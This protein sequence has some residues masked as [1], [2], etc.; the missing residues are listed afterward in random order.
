M[1]PFLAPE[2]V[3]SRSAPRTLRRSAP[4]TRPTAGPRGL[5]AGRRGELHQLGVVPAHLVR[6]IRLEVLTTV[7]TL[8]G[9][10]QLRQ[11]AAAGGLAEQPRPEAHYLGNKPTTARSGPLIW[12]SPR[13]GRPYHRTGGGGGDHG[14][15]LARQADAWVIGMGHAGARG[16]VMSL[17]A[18]ELFTVVGGPLEDSPGEVAVVFDLV[19]GEP[20][21]QRSSVVRRGGTA[22][23]VV[24]PPP[25]SGTTGPLHV[26]I[27]GGYHQPSGPATAQPPG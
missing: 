3:T 24:G 15:Q 9:R 21:N 11:G 17:G 19:G 2:D 20:L 4:Q 14:V 5:I 18:D 26:R 27:A 22:M 25:P 13:A 10:R 8:G 12:R 1:G 6:A 23:S 7:H 16:L